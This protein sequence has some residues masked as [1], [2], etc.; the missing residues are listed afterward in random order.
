MD[1]RTTDSRA[2]PPQRVGQ[3][4]RRIAR[5]ILAGPVVFGAAVVVMAG[6]ALWVPSGAAR[7]DNIVLPLVLFPAI[8]AVLFFYACLTRRLLRSYIVVAAIVLSNAA[9]LA[10]H[11]MS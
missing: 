11:L 4:T 6:G 3:R 1:G 9:M 2:R 10:R 5:V 8:W 7:I